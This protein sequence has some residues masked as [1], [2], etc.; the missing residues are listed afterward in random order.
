MTA[1]LPT[2]SPSTPT[3]VAS[4]T[5]S[6][7]SSRPNGDP[8]S[9]TFLASP[10]VIDGDLDDWTTTPYIA[11]ETVPNAADEWNGASDLS[12]TFYLGWDAENLYIAIR[13]TDDIFVQVSWGR[14]M[15]QGDDVE[16]QLDAD[17]AGDFYTT[18]MSTDDFQIGLSP[19][20]FDSLSPEAYRWHP[21]YL[22]SWLTN[23][24]V[25]AVQTSEGY[26]L[27]AAIPWSV[28]DVIPSTGN[29]YGF[30]MALSDND[31]AGV[32]AWQ[33]MVTNVTTRLTVN[34]T[35]WGTLIL[36]TP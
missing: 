13:R 10:P 23:V 25:A 18:T 20:N 14:Y 21:R 19:G 36:E 26:T 34:P 29:R 31:I 6:V 8:V 5:S 24:D 1:T 30:A 16:I 11:N 3:L 33:S 15:Y 2:D 32:S 22:E 28:F 4:A 9:A 35:T 17:L 27:E 12:A 7:L